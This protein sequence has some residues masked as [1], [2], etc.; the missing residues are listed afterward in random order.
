MSVLAVLAPVDIRPGMD[1][2]DE[3]DEAATN[4]ILPE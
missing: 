1:A 2:A 3:D 4:L